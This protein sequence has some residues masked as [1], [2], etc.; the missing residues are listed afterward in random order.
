MKIEV[1]LRINLITAIPESCSPNSPQS[2][3]DLVDYLTTQSLKEQSTTQQPFPI[4][5][6][7]H[8]SFECMPPSYPSQLQPEYAILDGLLG[9]SWSCTV[10]SFVSVFF[11]LDF[12]LVCLEHHGLPP[13]A[14]VSCRRSDWEEVRRSRLSLA[15]ISLIL[16]M[17]LFS[18]AFLMH[19]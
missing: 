6:S 11:F 9:V 16:A 2:L 15:F 18:R 1:S 14:Q 7:Y 17:S 10:V 8:W 3:V 19:L 13:H 4:H 12:L 5:G